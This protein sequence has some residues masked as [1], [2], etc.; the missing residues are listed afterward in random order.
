M[1]VKESVISLIFT[2]AVA[3]KGNTHDNHTG[4]TPQRHEEETSI[5]RISQQLQFLQEAK[6]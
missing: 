1:H 3:P 6:N 4:Y 5:N 2:K